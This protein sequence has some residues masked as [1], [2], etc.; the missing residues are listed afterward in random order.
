MLF[1]SEYGSVNDA[2]FA[3]VNFGSSN[4]YGLGVNSTGDKWLIGGSQGKINLA[5]YSDGEN[6][7]FSDQSGN[8]V[9]FGQASI[10]TITFN[11]DYWLVCGDNAKMN[12][13][14]LAYV[15]PG[16]AQSSSVLDWPS[17]YVSATLTVSAVLN[18]QQIDYFLSANGGSTWLSVTPGGSVYFSGINNGSSLKWRAVMR[19][20]DAF[21]SPRI[22]TLTINFDKNPDW[23]PTIT[24]TW[25]QSHTFT[26]TP[27]ITMTHTYTYTPTVTDTITMTNTPTVTPTVTQTVTETAT[28]TATPTITLTR[29]RKSVV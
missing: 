19:T 26:P 3:L 18:G 27:T 15:S 29:D 2:S 5:D 17:A 16:Y 6:E 9:N 14:G 25:T 1:R 13:Y 20:Y 23:T 8:L 7:I 21:I 28:P 22:E 11:N 10:N 12:R 4:I 24:P